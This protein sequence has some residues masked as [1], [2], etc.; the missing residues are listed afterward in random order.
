MVADRKRDGLERASEACRV[1]HTWD[2]MANGCGVDRRAGRLSIDDKGCF[3]RDER[4]S[5]RRARLRRE[6]R[7]TVMGE[8]DD[9]GALEGT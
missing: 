7:L 6:E 4:V 1:S 5:F 3:K 8:D 9:E 2:R